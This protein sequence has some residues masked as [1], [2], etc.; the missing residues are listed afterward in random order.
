[1]NWTS[2]V[3]CKVPIRDDLV[4]P[5]LASTFDA[6][7]APDLVG[8]VFADIQVNAWDAP[9]IRLP[10]AEALRRY[11]IGRQMA[12]EATADELAKRKA[13]PLTLTKRG[14]I[15]YGRKP[16]GNSSERTVRKS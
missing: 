2:A 16:L 5:D 11:L 12:N 1:M 9:L 3:F 13:F 15:V 4:P 14:A 6:E 8:S 10:D 7:V